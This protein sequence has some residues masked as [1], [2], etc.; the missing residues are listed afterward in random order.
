[1]ALGRSRA[2]GGDLCAPRC[3]PV[4]GQWHHWER[5]DDTQFSDI[6]STNPTNS[7]NLPSSLTHF[8]AASCC[9]L[10]RRRTTH[11]SLGLYS[12]AL[13][14]SLTPRYRIRARDFTGL[15]DALY[16]SGQS[17]LARETKEQARHPKSRRIYW[18]CAKR[19]GYPVYRR[20]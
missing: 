3:G 12:T 1:M 8:P 19:N 2:E 13:A 15:S 7:S 16:R 14:N 20:I 11:R 17:L 4:G 9:T 6:S 10:I 5:C 18:L